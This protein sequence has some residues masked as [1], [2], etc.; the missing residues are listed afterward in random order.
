MDLEDVKDSFGVTLVNDDC[1]AKAH[2]V[3]LIALSFSLKVIIIKGKRVNTYLVV[4]L[5]YSHLWESFTMLS[6]I[7]SYL[8][9]DYWIIVMYHS[10]LLIDIR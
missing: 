4:S 2:K 6:L 7:I 3:I 1:Y 8:Q 10:N 9:Q 5:Y